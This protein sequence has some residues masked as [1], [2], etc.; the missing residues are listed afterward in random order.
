MSHEE[1]PDMEPQDQPYEEDFEQDDQH[2]SAMPAWIVSIAVHSVLALILAAVVIGQ[3]VDIDEPPVRVVAAVIPEVLEE[4]PP[5][6]VKLEEQEVEIIIDP[7]VE[8]VTPNELNVEVENMEISDNAEVD[9][10]E[11]A[12]HAPMQANIGIGGG[13]FMPVGNITGLGMGKQG[14]GE[15]GFTRRSISSVN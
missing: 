11:P 6:E 8:V 7:E 12:P 5:E 13:A 10:S 4:E 9:T 14:K 15:R 1:T 2:V 3:Y